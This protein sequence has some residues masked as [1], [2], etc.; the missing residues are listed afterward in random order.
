MRADDASEGT[1]I[2]LGKD[3]PMERFSAGN[4]SGDKA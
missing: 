1:E 3:R 4:P 2:Q